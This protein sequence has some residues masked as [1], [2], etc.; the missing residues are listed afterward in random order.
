MTSEEESEGYDNGIDFWYGDPPLIS[1]FGAEGKEFM[2]TVIV[3]GKQ[4]QPDIY[5]E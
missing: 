3:S 4:M 5:S 2:P 1:F